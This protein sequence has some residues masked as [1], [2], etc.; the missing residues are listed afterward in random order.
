M[1][2]LV[3]TLKLLY[4]AHSKC[5]PNAQP[6]NSQLRD[7]L[8]GTMEPALWPLHQYS[9]LVIMATGEPGVL[10]SHYTYMYGKE[11]MK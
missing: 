6:E 1:G 7:L 4:F 8:T 5:S 2:T 3:A 10:T 9:H 11:D